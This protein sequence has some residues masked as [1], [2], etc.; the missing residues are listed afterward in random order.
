MRSLGG[1]RSP[2]GVKASLPG[3]VALRVASSLESRI[4]LDQPGAET[5]LGKGDLLAHLG[6][7]V[8]RA[9]AP[10]DGE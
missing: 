5:L 6:Q 10:F 8:V 4:I 1:D 2:N 7:G 9:Q 3:K